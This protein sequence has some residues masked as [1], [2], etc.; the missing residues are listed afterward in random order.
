M[1]ASEG[2]TVDIQAL[3]NELHAGKQGTKVSATR[4][5]AILDQ[6]KLHTRTL[7]SS[8]PLCSK[9]AIET[10]SHLGF[11]DDTTDASRVALKCLANVLL[12]AP[13]TRQIFLDLDLAPR[14]VSRIGSESSEDEFLASRLLLLSTYETTYDFGIV[15]TEHD[16]A[17]NMNRSLKKHSERPAS[18]EIE[19]Q[20]TIMALSETLKLLYNLTAAYPGRASL[21]QDSVDAIINLLMCLPLATPP[22]QPPT[23]HLIAAL[24]NLDLVPEPAPSTP[25]NLTPLTKRAVEIL[26]LAIPSAP[27]SV[28]PNAEN[29]IPPLLALLHKIYSQGPEPIRSFLKESLLPSASDRA[30][31]LG[32]TPTLPSSLLRLSTTARS[33]ILRDS[34]LNLLFELSGQDPTKLTQNIGFG[35]ASG[36]LWRNGMEIPTGVVRGGDEGGSVDGLDINPITG[37][38]R[39]AEDESDPMEG[40]TDEEKEREAEKLFVLFERFTTHFRSSS[41]RSPYVLQRC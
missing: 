8:D 38:R 25:N 3:L 21:L 5:G 31:P 27:I 15:F 7:S 39:D 33:P 28:P 17:Q 4:K 16:L 23:S 22:L 12:L 2:E 36:Y 9:S 19:D 40:W 10:L 1:A 13:P 29:S 30:L 26:K 20:Y 14:A 18:T 11:E 37:Q 41:E 24:I 6:I 35:Y 32:Q 34:I